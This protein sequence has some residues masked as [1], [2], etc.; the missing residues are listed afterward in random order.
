MYIGACYVDFLVRVPGVAC[1]TSSSSCDGLV[2]LVCGFA[3]PPN[4]PPFSL[5]SSFS[6]TLMLFRSLFFALS[7]NR[8]LLSVG[9]E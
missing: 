6:S 5:L 1:C 3:V 7:L 4:Q 8:A 2:E 9:F